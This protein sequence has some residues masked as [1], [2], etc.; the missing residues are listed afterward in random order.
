MGYFLFR[1]IIYAYYNFFIVFR[2]AH[3]V[4]ISYLKEEIT[5]E[6]AIAQALVSNGYE[7]YFYVH[8]NN[9]KHRNDI[10]IDFL[11]SNKS[12]TRYRIFPIEVKST[13]RYSTTSL[14]RF[15]EKYENRIGQAY[16][17][18]TKNL[19]VADKIL[20]IPAY[21]TNCL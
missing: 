21:M 17:I 9:E 3:C 7:P 6:N 2:L 18:H 16:V 1:G 20:Y 12:K 4:K 19:R 10:E 13:D 5:F 11:I 8:Y 14:E 15:I